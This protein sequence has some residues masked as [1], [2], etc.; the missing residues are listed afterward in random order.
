MDTG[1]LDSH[2]I[3]GLN[4]EMSER[5]TVRKVAT[6]APLHMKPYAVTVNKTIGPYEDQ[7]DEVYAGP[8]E[9]V[10][11]FTYEYNR[12]SVVVAEGYDLQFVLSP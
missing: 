4:A 6:C 11:N 9:G 3:L 1:P 2:S 7:W 8:I 5:V 10:E 12:H